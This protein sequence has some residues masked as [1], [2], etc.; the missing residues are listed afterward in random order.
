MSALTICTLTECKAFYEQ[1]TGVLGPVQSRGVRVYPYPRVYPTRPVPAGT[2]R[3]RVDLLRVGSGTGTTSTGTGVPGF[4]R[5]KPDFS[6]FWSYVH[7]SFGCTLYTQT[8][9][10]LALAIKR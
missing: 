2:G 7:C 10:Q 8:T 3:V 4:T 9:P 5:K 1:N 6:R